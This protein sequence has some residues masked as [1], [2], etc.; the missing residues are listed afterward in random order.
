MAIRH[1]ARGALILFAILGPAL[2]AW[3]A[4]Q[5]ELVLQGLSSPLYVAQPCDGSRR[6]FVVEQ[7]GRIR[8]LQPGATTPTIFLDITS[9][10]LSGGAPGMAALSAPAPTSPG[11]RPAVRHAL[12][13]ASSV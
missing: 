3:G 12:V 1:L 10:V 9:R 6:L 8:V 13:I 11:P 4:V 5:L 7:G 2:P